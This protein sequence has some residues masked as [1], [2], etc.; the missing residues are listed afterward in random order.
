MAKAKISVIMAVYNSEEFLEETIRNIINQTFNNFEFIVID[1][2]STDNSLNIIKNYTKQD[3]R[4][5]LIENKKN[6]GLTKSLNKGLRIAKGKYIARIDAD[7]IALSER[8]EKQYKYLEEH[9]DIFLIG[10]AALVIDK[11]GKEIKKY[12]PIVNENQLKRLLKKGNA[13][14]H[15]TVM[16]RNEKNNFYREKFYYSQDYDFYLTMLLKGKR[17][18]NIPDL[19]IK[20]RINPEAISFSQRTKQK[21]FA[22]KAKEFY[23][24]R[25]K[26]GKDEYDKFNPSEIL[27]IDV[28]KSID[29]MVL[30]AEIKASF[31]L[32]NLK[33]AKKF[34]RKYF[35][36]YGFFNKYIIYYTLSFMGEKFINLV[37]KILFN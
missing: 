15:P 3:K 14:Y 6:I 23:H 33:R 31:K 35:K 5:I 25:L 24:Q 34:C 27:S 18:I 19:L 9:Q 30:A 26:H 1:D 8:L 11:N 32:N 13:I 22:E 16:F 2:C 29:K 7:D 20:Y 12:K 4:I 37:R 10:G 17:L 36:Y 21:L 28:E